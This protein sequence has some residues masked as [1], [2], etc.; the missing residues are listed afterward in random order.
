[1]LPGILILLVLVHFILVTIFLTILWRI[2]TSLDAV[3]RTLSD[4]ARDLKKP[5]DIGGK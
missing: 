3:S 2:A 5:S 1:M 4:I